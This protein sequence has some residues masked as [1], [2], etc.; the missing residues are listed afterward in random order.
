M[1]A[2]RL[3]HSNE[4]RFTWQRLNP[5]CKS[6]LDYWFIPI[7]LENN[8]AECQ[9]ITAPNTDHLAVKL[10]LSTSDV[11]RGKGVWKFNNSLLED[12]QY[13]S[14]IDDLIK[15]CR[16]KYAMNILRTLLE[17]C[18][19]VLLNVFFKHFLNVLYSRLKN[20]KKT[21]L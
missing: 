2:W 9:I 19:D 10:K 4:K 6:T 12:E 8:V 18:H 13:T 16:N 21:F 3:K 17:Y 5:M 1:D 11:N 7:L 20:V 14:Q 15:T